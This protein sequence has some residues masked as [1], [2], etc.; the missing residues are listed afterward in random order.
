MLLS[1]SLAFVLTFA[2]TGAPA[3]PATAQPAPPTG[4]VFPYEDPGACPTDG[5]RYG[6]WVA[7]RS[8]TVRRARE[9]GAAPVF[10]VGAGEAVDAVTGVVV[11]L[12]PGRARAVAPIDV[13]GVRIVTGEHVLLLRPA[14]HGVYR[15]SAR[16]AVVDTALDVAGRH[17]AVL[18]EPRTVWWVQ[19]RNRRGEVGWTSEPDAFSD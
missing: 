2:L 8:L 19:V 14:G 17:L 11:T 13:D 3:G 6:R 12:R 9:A 18:S 4:L 1:P 15:V 16:G 10:R 5:C 7:A